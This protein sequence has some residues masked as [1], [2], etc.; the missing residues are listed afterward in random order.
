MSLHYLN[1][2]DEPR[3][4]PGCDG[5]GRVETNSSFGARRYDPHSKMR[6]CNDC[7][8]TGRLGVEGAL[9]DVEIAEQR[10][11]W[12]WALVADGDLCT[13]FGPFPTET[14]ALEAARKSQR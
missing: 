2:D 7:N 5:W 14:A 6:D 9:P 3:E 11:E 12:K 10:G 4:C 8:G 1:P 13:W